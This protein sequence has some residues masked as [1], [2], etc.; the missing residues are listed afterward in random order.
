MSGSPALNPLLPG[1]NDLKVLAEQTGGAV[2]S[3]L[4]G[5]SHSLT[6]MEKTAT[7]GSV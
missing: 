1:M 2:F 7:T 3:A 5:G 4:A 6:N